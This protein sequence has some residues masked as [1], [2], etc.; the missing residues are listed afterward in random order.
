M[1]M[2]EA[3]EIPLFVGTNAVPE[4]QAGILRC[5][6]N[7][8]TGELSGPVVAADIK[9]PSF[10][11]V[12]S[13]GRFLHAAIEQ[14]G[15]EVAAF[16]ILA[17]HSLVPLNRR[18]SGGKGTC[19]VWAGETH[20]FASNYT[21]GSVT[22]FPILP[23]GALGEATA[24]VV[25]SGSGPN[26]VRQQ[27]PYAHGAISTPDGKFVY[28]CDLGTDQVWIFR[29]DRETGRMIAGDPPSGKVPS[30]GGPRHPVLGPGGD[31]LYVNNEM[32]VSVSTFVR[33]RE[34]GALS[35]IQTIPTLPEGNGHD[36]VTTSGIVLHPS[37]RWLYVSNRGHNSISVFEIQ[38]DGKLKFVQ[39]T[40]STVDMPRE[41]AVDPSGTWLVVGGQKDGV[42]ASMKIHGADGTLSPA[43][44]LATDAVPVSF[45]F[46]P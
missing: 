11:A 15:G 25:F 10:L 35:L 12:S 18:L 22:C 27:K 17:D 38:S 28:V 26:P 4:K 42:I 29:F 45:S 43:G 20:V 6:L 16:R 24:D 33:D 1:G 39:N 21:G 46:L 14:E 9:S 36:G 23:D 31:F 34:T 37:G 13:D 41:F 19:H 7:L 3:G 2:I 40:H 5:T 30:G 8:E 32:G 44:H